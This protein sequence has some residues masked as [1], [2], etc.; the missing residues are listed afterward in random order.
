M[1][2]GAMFAVKH[3]LDTGPSNLRCGKF[4]GLVVRH[5][6]VEGTRDKLRFLVFIHRCKLR[7][8]NTDHILAAFGFAIQVTSK[9][10]VKYVTLLMNK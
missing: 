7:S 2:I 6:E 9:Q 5:Q 3:L 8:S 10:N 1:G 4:E